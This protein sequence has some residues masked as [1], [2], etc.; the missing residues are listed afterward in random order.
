M[1]STKSFNFNK[2][3]LLNTGII[4][5]AI[6]R[7]GI[8]LSPKS[9][10]SANCTI[11]STAA[12]TNLWVTVSGTKYS[13][14]LSGPVNETAN[15]N[16]DD[17]LEEKVICILIKMM[18]DKWVKIL[19]ET[20]SKEQGHLAIQ[21]MNKTRQAVEA[22]NFRLYF[23]VIVRQTGTNAGLLLFVI[24]CRAKLLKY[25]WLMRRAFFLNSGQK[26]LDPD[27]LKRFILSVRT[28]YQKRTQ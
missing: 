14:K 4:I 28:K 3:I 20:N 7:Y 27:W 6:M 17:N 2:F 23:K 8:P 16:T 18:P 26:L 12:P 1:I 24:I 13:Y 15:L 5:G 10:Y 11:N 19:K 25:D 9:H 22:L 21:N